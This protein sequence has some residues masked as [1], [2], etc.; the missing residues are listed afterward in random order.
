MLISWL[1]ELFVFASDISASYMF[2]FFIKETL[3]EKKK[4]RE[5]RGKERDRYNLFTIFIEIRG[6]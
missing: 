2:T 1:F 3:W 5:K 6:R 4:R